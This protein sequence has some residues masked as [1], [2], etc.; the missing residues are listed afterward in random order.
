[1]LGL[2]NRS[3]H[4]RGHLQLQGPAQ[5]KTTPSKAPRG[6][7]TLEVLAGTIALVLLLVPWVIFY[8]LG[9]WGFY[10]G[11]RDGWPPFVSC[12]RISRPETKTI[13]SY[14]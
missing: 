9:P 8:W 1:M 13:D 2:V 12:R 5:H 6:G 4:G 11:P 14:G 7:I 3:T 10:V